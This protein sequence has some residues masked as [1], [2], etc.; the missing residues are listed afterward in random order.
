MDSIDGRCGCLNQKVQTKP[1]P[2]TTP[3]THTHNAAFLSN[4]LKQ[5]NYWCP[6]TSERTF[7]HDL[8]F[9]L[10]LKLQMNQKQLNNKILDFK[11]DFYKFKSMENCKRNHTQEYKQKVMKGNTGDWTRWRGMNGI[12]TSMYY[13]ALTFCCKKVT[14]HTGQLFNINNYE[15]R[16]SWSIK[17]I[18]DLACQECIYVQGCVHH[19]QPTFKLKTI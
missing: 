13:S 12:A 2:S 8:W 1:K 18:K 15:W 5:I 9:A 16:G 10:K 3:K 17:Q 4:K 6:D 11:L 19:I 7:C 14:G